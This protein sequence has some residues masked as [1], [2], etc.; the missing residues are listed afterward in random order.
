MNRERY[1]ALAT[2]ASG[3]VDRGEYAR[4]IGIFEEIAASELPDF[5]LGITWVN[6]ATVEDKRGRPEEALACLARAM[7]Y[8]RKTDSCFIA[9]HRAAYLSKL[10]RHRE[11]LS[12]Y[13]DLLSRPDLKPEDAA[14][15]RAN[16][17]T[18]EKLLTTP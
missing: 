16:I 10:G 4:A 6:I 8:E 9:Q 7:D 5:D 17:S 12:A 3:L 2:E 14:V 13:R 15:F 11:S 18:L 1:V